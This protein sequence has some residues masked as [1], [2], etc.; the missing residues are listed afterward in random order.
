MPTTVT[1]KSAHRSSFVVGIIH[2]FGA[3]TPTQ[4]LLV[5]MTAK[6]GG[7]GVGLLGLLLFIFDMGRVNTLLCVVMAQNIPKEGQ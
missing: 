6:L 5:L 1:A 2:G 3:E 4:L 7:V